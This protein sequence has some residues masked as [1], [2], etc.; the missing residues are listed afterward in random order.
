LDSNL[1]HKRYVE[2]I[3][4]NKLKA[5]SA[6]CWPCYIGE[7]VS[8]VFSVKTSR[9]YLQPPPPCFIPSILS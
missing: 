2:V 3:N 7:Y 8:L 4:R 5:N 9:L 1:E 6:S